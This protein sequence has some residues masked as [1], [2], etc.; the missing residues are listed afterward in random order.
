[1]KVLVTGANGMLGSD[2]CKILQEEG[3]EVTATNTDN[4]D[5]TKKDM[6]NSFLKGEKTDIVI[7]LAG[8]TNVD[9][10]ETFPEEAF[11]INSTGTENLANITAAMNIPIIYISTDYVFNGTKNSPYE[12]DDETNPINIY[13]ESKLKGEKSIQKTNPKHY[14]IRTS[15]LYG[16]N[17]KNFVETIISLGK[18]KNPL[19]IVNDQ[20]GCPTWTLELSKAIVN[21][22]KNKKAYGIYHICGSGQATWYEF[23]K[24]ILEL[25]E[26]DT[27]VLPVLTSEFPR[28]AKRPM[29]SVMNS[30]N[31][32]P[33]WEESLKKYIEIRKQEE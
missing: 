24:K 6:I 33:D 11:L 20:T 7:H 14:I 1:M 25:M 10:A 21:L 15:W 28:P 32:C 26:I 19:K 12:T 29:Y 31:A 8:Y 27:H 30:K 2:L 16:H 18:K 4:L 13:G 3:F 17:G 23:A 5:I 22:I 9:G